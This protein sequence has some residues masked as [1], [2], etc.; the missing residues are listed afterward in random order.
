MF[1]SKFKSACDVI[2]FKIFRNIVSIVFFDSGKQG[3]ERSY[4]NLIYSEQKNIEIK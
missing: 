4:K 3:K 1:F 2:D